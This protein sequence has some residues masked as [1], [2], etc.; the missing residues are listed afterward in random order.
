[1]QVYGTPYRSCVHCAQTIVAREGWRAFYY[2]FS[3]QLALNIPYQSLHFVV[4]E[5]VQNILNPDRQY[6][7]SSHVVSGA[8]AGAVAAALTTPFDVCK[9]LL[10]TQES[11]AVAQGGR[12]V[13]GIV[14]AT[15]TVYELRGIKGFF[16]GTSARVLFQIPSTA[17]AWFVYEFF[18]YALKKEW[19]RTHS[20]SFA[21]NGDA[22]LH[23]VASKPKS[24][25][26]NA[27]LC[28]TA[29]TGLTPV[30]LAATPGSVH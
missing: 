7:P 21:G 20:G 16:S 29:S 3:T 13:H 10:N 8:A 15:R 5:F 25:S 11:G 30:Q 18:K 23:L 22:E 26:C 1:M 14:S 6:L 4:Y 2:S 12:N 9:T 28:S 27:Q 19:Q 17:I 24:D